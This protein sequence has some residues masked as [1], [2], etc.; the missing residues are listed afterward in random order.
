MTTTTSEGYTEETVAVGFGDVFLMKGGQGAPLVVLQDDIGSP[1]W[2]PFYDALAQ[3]FTVYVPHHPGFG[4][5]DRPAWMR[6]VRDM[7]IAHLWL[8]DV[9]QLDAQP[10]PVVGLGLGGW[11]AAEMA[12]MRQ[13]QFERLVL[14]GAVGLQPTSG[15]IVDQFLVSGE[16]YAKSCFHDAAVFE[17]WYG[18]E[19]TVDQ[20]EAWEINREMVVR[21]AW[22]P[23]MFNQGL[24]FLLGAVNTPT[25]VV[26]G[27]EDGIVPRS[28]A[29]RYVEV[30]P[31]ARLEELD[32]CGHCADVEQP[33]ELAALITRFIA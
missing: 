8:F 18:K 2:L 31:H 11:V 23:Y 1:G 20:R 27:R 13:R 14:V 7:A 21:V 32:R 22:K 19:T 12:T 25:L 29:T 33:E 10:L 4:R 28:C 17:T 6:N 26:R 16:E 30:L 5:S 15:E 9:L 3:Q 24:P